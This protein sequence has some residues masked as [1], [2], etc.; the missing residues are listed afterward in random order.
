MKLPSVE[1]AHAYLAEGGQRNPGPWVRHSR[2]AAETARSI[3]EHHPTL[4]ADAAFVMALLQSANL[5]NRVSSARILDCAA[6]SFTYACSWP[7]L[8][9]AATMGSSRLQHTGTSRQVCRNGPLEDCHGELAKPLGIDD[10][11]D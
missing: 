11:L 9:L 7:G 8:T 6:N 2:V 10:H 5:F 4:D 1:Q 3:A